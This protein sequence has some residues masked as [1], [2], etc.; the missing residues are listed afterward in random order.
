M[1]FVILTLNNEFKKKKVK[2]CP[3]NVRQETLHRESVNQGSTR[4]QKGP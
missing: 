3:A 4:S 1:M 2:K